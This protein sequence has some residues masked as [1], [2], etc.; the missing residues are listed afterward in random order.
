MKIQSKS[1]I[2][3][4]IMLTFFRSKTLGILKSMFPAIFPKLFVFKEKTKR[5]FPYVGARGKLLAFLETF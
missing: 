1:L 4:N 5:L 2:Y 3:T